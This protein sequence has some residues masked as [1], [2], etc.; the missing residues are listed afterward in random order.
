MLATALI[1]DGYFTTTGSATT[2][3]QK[4]LLGGQ[5][6]QQDLGSAVL[7]QIR[8]QWPW[9]G[10]AIQGIRKSYLCR[11]RDLHLC[12]LGGFDHHHQL[13]RGVCD[14][15]QILASHISWGVLSQVLAEEWYTKTHKI[16]IQHTQFSRAKSQHAREQQYQIHCSTEHI[17]DRH[18]VTLRACMRTSTHHSP[19]IT[20]HIMKT[21]S[22][23]MW[24]IFF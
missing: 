10:P 7:V 9:A 6:S 14:A 22:N 23:T 15:A 12:L 11:V 5:N 19:L 20:C 24:M 17:R 13:L 8:T 21:H 18:A 16:T 2:Q 1:Q 4:P 3:S